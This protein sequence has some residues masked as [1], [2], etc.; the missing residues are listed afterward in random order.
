LIQIFYVD[1]ENMIKGLDDD[2]IEFLDLIDRTKMAEERK[3]NLEDEKEMQ[4]FKAAV[5]SLQEKSLDERLKLELK[6]PQFHNKST[7]SW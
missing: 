3:K 5:A 6:Q 4:D 2:E 7:S 1:I